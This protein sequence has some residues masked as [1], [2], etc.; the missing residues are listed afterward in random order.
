MKK[1]FLFI[2]LLLLKIG[3]QAQSYSL[4]DLETLFIQNNYLLLAQKYNIQRVDAELLQEKVWNNPSLTV[5]EVN[6]WKNSSHEELPLLFGKYG[7]AQQIS[8]EL[9]QLIETAGKRK[10]R[11]ILK[12]VEKDNALLEYEELM[13]QL[14]KELR[15]SFY[16]VERLQAE[17]AQ[18]QTVVMLFEELQKQYAAQ[19]QKQQVSQADFYRTQSELVTLQR[20]LMALGSQKAESLSTIQVLTQL[21]NL[22]TH[23]LIFDSLS[24]VKLPSLPK[25]LMEM[26]LA[27]N[28]G[29][30][31]QENT[32][33]F[34]EK[35]LVLESAMRKPD[36]T[37]KLGYDRGGNIMR[38]F[39]G[40]GAQ[41][42][43]PVF[44]KNKGNIKAA[45]FNIEQER[46]TAASL[47]AEVETTVFRLQS[48]LRNYEV[49]LQ[50]WEKER[51]MDQEK[52]WISYNKH[53]QSR[54]ITLL[55]FIDFT[56]AYKVALQSRMQLVEDYKNTYEE[57]QYIVGIDF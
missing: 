5:D 40:I 51:I 32:A 23:H 47:R 29:M 30:K 33:L 21:P 36:V 43:L 1:N 39:V 52:M 3:L 10:K 31:R 34:A 44:N 8:I 37:L 26:A 28:I 57:L 49:L 53:L 35:R 22:N 42:D 9:E 2:F 48:Q 14:K 15:Q 56:Q 25:N 19:V 18:L 24:E 46:S 12:R 20:E 6:L 54:Q 27:Q 7:K 55:E 38:D 16:K 11:V 41:V 50:R 45:Q 4:A 17:E 13:L